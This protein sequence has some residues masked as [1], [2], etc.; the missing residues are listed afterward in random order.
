MFLSSTFLS[1]LLIY[2]FIPNFDCIKSWIPLG[3]FIVFDGLPSDSI[4]VLIVT[5]IC[6]LTSAKE[7]RMGE[8]TMRELKPGKRLLEEGW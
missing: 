7:R 2:S 3:I 5:L 1:S 6:V 4:S 8:K